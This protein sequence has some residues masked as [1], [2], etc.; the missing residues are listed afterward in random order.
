MFC[1]LHSIAVCGD[2]Y[3]CAAMS[4]KRDRRIRV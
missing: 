4:D 1:E 2:N 3:N